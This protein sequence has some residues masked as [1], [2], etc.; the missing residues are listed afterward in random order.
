MSANQGLRDC[1]ETQTKLLGVEPSSVANATPLLKDQQMSDNSCHTE[2]Q[3]T[4]TPG[5]PANAPP[6]DTALHT[7]AN[8]WV[9][10]GTDLPPATYGNISIVVSEASPERF[11]CVFFDLCMGDAIL[12]RFIQWKGERAQPFD[13]TQAHSLLCR[14]DDF[15]T[16]NFGYENDDDDDA[17][18]VI[19]RNYNQVLQ[20]LRRWGKPTSHRMAVPYLNLLIAPA[21]EKA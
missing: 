10:E 5:E 6:R 18:T 11:G 1:P 12:G 21:G 20:W 7:P 3:A 15:F 16:F 13:E 19:E 17:A 9:D 14:L 2:W 4:L 8:V